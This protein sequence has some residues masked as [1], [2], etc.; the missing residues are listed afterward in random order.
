MIGAG[1]L[2]FELNLTLPVAA[3]PG[4]VDAD[5]RPGR[6]Q[7][8][9][10]RLG[11][12]AAPAGHRPAASAAH[13]WPAL[14]PGRRQLSSSSGPTSAGCSPA[15]R[16]ACWA[17]SPARPGRRRRRPTGG[18]GW[19]G[20][21]LDTLADVAAG[22]RHR[23]H[24][25]RARRLRRRPRAERRCA[26]RAAGAAARPLLLVTRA[27]PPPVW[28]LLVLF[29]LF[30]GPLP[31]A[32]ALGIYNF[33]IL[34]RLMA[35]VVENLDPRPGCRA[36]GGWARGGVGVRL[37]H[38][39]AVGRP[40]RRLLALPVGGRRAGD[41]RRRRRRRRRARPAP[42]AAAR[43]LQLPG[44]ARHGPRPG[45]RLDRSST[46]SAPPPGARCAGVR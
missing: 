37:R 46:W 31:G 13:C 28:A 24:A 7:R 15:R 39:A 30:P 26:R 9:G 27:I 43:R 21:S 8:A 33:G 3:L 36:A 5:L 6:H 1:G 20:A 41:R 14:R 19:S 22:H 40:L 11:G 17:T 25:G 4:D 16:A 44:H 38:A 42:G 35:E 12:D 18:A 45:R 10:R 23:Q 2:G 29:V 32:V 34:G